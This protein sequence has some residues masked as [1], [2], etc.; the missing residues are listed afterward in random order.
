MRSTS[1]IINAYIKTSTDKNINLNPEMIDIFYFSL[2]AA[3]SALDLMDEMIPS[4]PKDSN[5]AARME[6]VK[7]TYRGITTM[8]VGAESMLRDKARL[9]LPERTKVLDAMATTIPR[10]KDAFTPGYRIELRKRLEEDRNLFLKAE[11]IQKIDIMI[12]ILVG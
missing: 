12:N 4:I 10:L 11:D 6:G 5:Y 8:I 7:I 3:A 1:L 9:T 2:H